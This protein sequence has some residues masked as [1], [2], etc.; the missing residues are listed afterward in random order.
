LARSHRRRI[1]RLVG[2]GDEERNVAGHERAETVRAE[3]IPLH[4]ALDASGA[5]EPFHIEGL[6]DGE[7]LVE[8]EAESDG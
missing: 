3:G 7:T 2:G 6:R 1:I 5:A 4:L 8:V